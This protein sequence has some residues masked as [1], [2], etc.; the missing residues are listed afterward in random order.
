MQIASGGIAS[1]VLPTCAYVIV[2]GKRVPL[3]LDA[4]RRVDARRAGSPHESTGS[5]GTSGSRSRTRTG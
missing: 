5:I 4:A 2:D 1:G 3:S